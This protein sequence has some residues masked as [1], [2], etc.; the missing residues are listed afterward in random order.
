MLIWVNRK[1]ARKEIK[2]M[3]NAFFD[4]TYDKVAN[5][6]NVASEVMMFVESIVEVAWMLGIRDTTPP[7]SWTD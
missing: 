7:S 3:W 4:H 5:S 6:A 2:K 1:K